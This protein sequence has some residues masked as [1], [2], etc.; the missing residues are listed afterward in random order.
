MCLSWEG[1]DRQWAWNEG[2]LRAIQGA[3][4]MTGVDEEPCRHTFPAAWGSSSHWGSS[5]GP[6]THDQSFILKSSLFISSFKNPSPTQSTY[7]L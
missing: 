3:V 7:F 4:T 1:E 6:E 2:G 5:C